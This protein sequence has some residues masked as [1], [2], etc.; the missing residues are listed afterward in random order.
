MNK[1][2]L[3]AALAVATTSLVSVSNGA[4]PAYTDL[5]IAAFNALPK[6][7]DMPNGVHA[8]SKIKGLFAS[9]PNKSSH[10]W[11]PKGVRYVG[12]F[13]NDEDAAAYTADKLQR[14]GRRP[15]DS[16]VEQAATVCFNMTDHWQ[17]SRDDREWPQRLEQW[18]SI[19]SAA[20]GSEAAKEAPDYQKPRAFR[21]ERLLL[22]Q[23]DAT[24]HL[25]EGWFDPVSLGARETAAYQVPFKEVAAGPGGVRVFGARDEKSG[26]VE[27]VVYTPEVEQK[28]RS[29]LNGGIQVVRSGQSGHS[30]CGHARV[31][32]RVAPGSGEQGTVQLDVLLED[33]T[34]EAVKVD[35]PAADKLR[36]GLF[37]RG[38]DGPLREIRMRTLLVNVGASQAI[39]DEAPV[40][41]VTFGWRGPSRTAQVF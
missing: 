37:Q 17:L 30:D 1:R 32:L 41:T 13:A 36:R 15:K 20:R 21:V 6:A 19:R 38:G 5:P 35:A 26:T 4:A 14:W 34:T 8:K 28:L 40:T 22:G 2:I 11:G 29:H 3:A 10:R 24:L 31:S 9:I 7:A 39:E 18:P 16:L 33:K 25:Q 12:L 27:I 23:A